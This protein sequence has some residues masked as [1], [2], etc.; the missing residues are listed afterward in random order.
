MHQDGRIIESFSV[1]TIICHL[2]QLNI[3][4]FHKAFHLKIVDYEEFKNFTIAL[5]NSTITRR[6]IVA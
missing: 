1:L 6:G 4:K 5:K 3:C 2:S